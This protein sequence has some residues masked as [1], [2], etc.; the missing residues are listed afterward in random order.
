MTEEGKLLARTGMEDVTPT[1]CFEH[2]VEKPMQDVLV[3]CW[4]GK[5]WSEAVTGQMREG[6]K[7]QHS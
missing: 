6:E 2:G 1:L 3:S 5:L 4:V 7:A